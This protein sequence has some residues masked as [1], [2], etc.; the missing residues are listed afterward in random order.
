MIRIQKSFT[1]GGFRD[2]QLQTWAWEHFESFEKLPNLGIHADLFPIIQQSVAFFTP[3]KREI[4]H[5]V[6][7]KQYEH[8]GSESISL[9]VQENL[10]VLLNSNSVTVVTGQQI[11]PLLGPVFVWNKIVSTIQTAREINKKYPDYTAVPVFWMATE[12]HDFEEI[13]RIPFLNK[14]YVWEYPVLKQGVPVGQ[15]PTSGIV[16]IINQMQ[17]DFAHELAWVDFLEGCKVHYLKFTNLADATRSL[18]NEWFGDSGLLVLDPMDSELKKLGSSVFQGETNGKNFDLFETQSQELK[19]LQI[20]PPVHHRNTHLFYFENADENSD[21]DA[22]EK[23]SAQMYKIRRRIDFKEDRFTALDSIKSWSKEQFIEEL[24]AHP[25]RFSPNVILRPAY[26]QALLPNVVY[27]A[28]PAEFRYWM[29]VP[30]VIS[31]NGLAVPRLQLRLSSAMMT[32]AT[33]KKMDQIGISQEELFLSESALVKIISDSFE[34]EFQLD[35]AIEQ[36]NQQMEGVRS[37][38]HSIGYP[39]L[40]EVKK[41]QEEMIKRLRQASKS[42]KAGE[43]G[44]NELSRKLTKLSQLKNAGFDSSKPWERSTFIFELMLK[45]GFRWDINSLPLDGIDE[46]IWFFDEK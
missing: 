27:V 14:E 17:S 25:E 42:Y 12:D 6:L 41:E 13:A 16:S 30:S 35:Q 20:Q 31:S 11:H 10:N 37:Q 21:V 36:L 34:N 28:G 29:Q 5:G 33:Q 7:T 9:E 18:V 39:S 24:Q 46:F 40:K 44:E 22:D 19:S 2:N 8:L 1:P 38:L 32:A 26:Q 15:L 43:W 23:S 3:E 45:F 4:L